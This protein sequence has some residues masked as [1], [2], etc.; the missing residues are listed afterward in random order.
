MGGSRWVLKLGSIS[1]AD[2]AC[3]G[4]VH[5]LVN[6]FVVKIEGG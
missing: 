6:C 5:V 1:L 2:W 3:S 4:D